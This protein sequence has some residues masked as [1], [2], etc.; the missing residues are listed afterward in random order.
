ML[1]SIASAPV[2]TRDQDDRVVLEKC[3]VGVAEQAGLSTLDKGRLVE[4]CLASGNVKN[5]VQR[6]RLLCM[7]EPQQ[8]LDCKYSVS[9]WSSFSIQETLKAVEKYALWN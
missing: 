7:S 1:F 4:E 5:P 2:Q 3:N 6:I 8:L 9:E